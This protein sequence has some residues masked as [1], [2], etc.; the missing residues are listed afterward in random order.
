MPNR[1]SIDSAARLIARMER[2]PFT[3]WHMKARIVMGSATFFD[4]YNALSLARSFYSER[5]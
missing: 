2:V 4:A 3:P 1:S 5:G